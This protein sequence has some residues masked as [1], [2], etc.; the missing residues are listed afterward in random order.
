MEAVAPS[1]DWR[2]NVAAPPRAMRSGKSF[3]QACERRRVER[4]S[5]LRDGVTAH[6]KTY[7]T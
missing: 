4:V 3:P 1:A 7:L 2:Y 6:N 5:S